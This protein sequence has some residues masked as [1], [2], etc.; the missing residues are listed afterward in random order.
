MAPGRPTLATPRLRLAPA[1]P[2]DAQALQ[3]LWNEPD[4]KRF[5]WDDESVTLDR[6]RETIEAGNASFRERNYG[7]WCVNLIHSG[8][9]AGFCGLREFGEAGEVEILYG[10]APSRTGQGYATE[11]AR[12]ALHHGFRACGLGEIWGR[13]DEPNLRSVRV[14][15]RLGMTLRRTSPGVRHRILEYSVASSQY[16]GGGP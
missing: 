2:G 7:L 14:L 6:A 8:V 16:P 3:S 15:D 10:L 1:N 5:L 13:T 11:A 4:V 12:A 9:L